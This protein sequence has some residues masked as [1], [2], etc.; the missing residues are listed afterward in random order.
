MYTEWIYYWAVPVAEA[1]RRK[2]IIQHAEQRT[3]GTP[4]SGSYRATPNVKRQGAGGRKW[5][6]ERRPR[7]REQAHEAE[8]L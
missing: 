5:I 2:K 1:A 3:R 6:K 7:R 8:Y 4:A